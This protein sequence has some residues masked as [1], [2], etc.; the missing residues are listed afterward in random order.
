MAGTDKKPAASPACKLASSEER[1]TQLT[2]V[3]IASCKFR[4]C[5]KMVIQIVAQMLNKQAERSLDE[6]S[7]I[8][9]LGLSRR[10]SKYHN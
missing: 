4:Q 3:E 7:G 6:Q 9:P 5:L 2:R 1:P 8:L 10:S